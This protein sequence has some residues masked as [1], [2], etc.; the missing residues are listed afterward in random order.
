MEFI[1]CNLCEQN[2]AELLFSKNMFKIVRCNNCGLVYVNPTLEEAGIKIVYE[3]E[4]FKGAEEEV[5][6][7][8]NLQRARF[9]GQ[10]KRIEMYKS[11]G[12]LL[13]IGCSVGYFLEVAKNS[14][15]DVW[16][17]EP[18]SF[19]GEEARRRISVENIFVGKIEEFQNPEDFFDVVTMWQ[20]LEHSRDPFLVLKM[21]HQ[22][23]KKDGILIIEVPN[24]D[25]S[26]SKKFKERWDQIHPPL[27]LYYFAPLTL[28]NLLVKAGFSVLKIEQVPSGT[29][30][31]ER[32]KKAKVDGFR[33]FLLAHFG[34]LFWLKKAILSWKNILKRN[35]FIIAYAKKI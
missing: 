25:C 26:I 24:F 19:A 9:R 4:Y 31:G 3:Q 20:V 27:H 29:G 22:M 34:S 2:N 35:D 11:C 15:W 5:L 33:R 12:K 18:S 13:D 21:T 8:A 1:N 28:S 32:L 6:V 16:G 7:E 14:G 10:L 17:I 30:I 23:L